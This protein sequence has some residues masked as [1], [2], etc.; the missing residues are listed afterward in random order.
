LSSK[1]CER[2]KRGDVRIALEAGQ[3]DGRIK[4]ALYILSNFGGVWMVGVGGYIG[5]MLIS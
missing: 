4:K 2:K 1:K 3:K 5:Q